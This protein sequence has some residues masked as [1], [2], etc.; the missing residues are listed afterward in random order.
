MSHQERSQKRAPS[1]R[2]LDRLESIGPPGRELAVR[3]D[4]LRSLGPRWAWRRFRAESQYER[5][6]SGRTPTYRV[7]WEEA[8]DA[9]GA[10][11]VDLSGGF[12]EIRRNSCSTRVW[13]QYVQ[14]DDWVTLRFALEKTAVHHL[15]D[16]AGLPVPKHIEF[17]AADIEPALDFLA[18]GPT[19]C[20]VKPASSS[21]GSGT[22]S[23]IS[24]AH[25][26][27]RARLRAARL[28]DRLLIERQAAGDVHR[29]LFL[30]DR[31]LDA[32][33]R[34]PPTVVGDGRSTIGQL[35]EDENRRRAGSLYGLPMLR[36]DLEC[37]FTLENAGLTLSSVPD[38]DVRV[39]VKTVISQNAPRDNERVTDSVSAALVEEAARAARVVGVRL[40]GV[41]V[42]VPRGEP[43]TGAASGVFLEVN[44]GPGLHYH[45]QVANPGPTSRV[46]IPILEALLRDR[47]SEL[48]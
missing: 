17:D 36:I 28:A 42:V 27:A 1:L 46:A 25:Q 22:T 5:H 15:L 40:A 14:L 10:E 4:L 45:Y 32:I 8:A 19:P 38:R 29:L 35:I 33:C 24:T 12:F 11:I 7:I 37:I 16:Q 18:Q 48:P 3:L 30:D 21:G 41:D 23:G 31:L 26:L 39:A 20:V 34:R 9:L 2:A 47:G 43:S 6:D 13:N 44:G